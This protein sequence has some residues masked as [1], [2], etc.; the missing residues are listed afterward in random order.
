MKDEY[1]QS[2]Y[3]ETLEMDPSR[4][5]LR[6]S[7]HVVGTSNGDVDWQYG[8]HPNSRCQCS[9][10]PGDDQR[11]NALITLR[12]IEKKLKWERGSERGRERARERRGAHRWKTFST[13]SLVMMNVLRLPTNTLDLI[14]L[15]SRPFVLL[16]IFLGLT[17]GSSDVT[18]T[19]CGKIQQQ[20]T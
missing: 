10:R 3:M 18:G 17:M 16:L 13:N 15:G 19:V 14:E 12:E 1:I 4:Q 9:K 5:L 6:T 7:C 20:R 8:N 2:L 11:I